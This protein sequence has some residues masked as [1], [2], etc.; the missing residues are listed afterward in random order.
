MTADQVR[1][2]IAEFASIRGNPGDDPVA[3][4]EAAL[5]VEEVFGLELTDDDMTAEALGS[6]RTIERLVITR[7]GVR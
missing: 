7:L 1:E 3:R 4:L 5:F 6:H 2:R